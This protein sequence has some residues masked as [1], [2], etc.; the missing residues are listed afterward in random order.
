MYI[1]C[2]V[3]WEYFGNIK[4]YTVF[5]LHLGYKINEMLKANFTVSNLLD[6]KHTEIIGGPAIGRVA[7]LRLTTTF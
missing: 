1:L 6:Y 7:L 2:I 4:S 5:D 3:I